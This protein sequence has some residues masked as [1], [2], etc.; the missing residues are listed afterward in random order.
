VLATVTPSGIPTSSRGGAAVIAATVALA[1][2]ALA[3][4]KLD[5]SVLYVLPALVLLVLLTLRRYPGERI[6]AVLSGAR[7]ERPRR[8][9]SSLPLRAR[10]QVAVPRGGLLLACSLA[11]RPPPSVQ[12]AAS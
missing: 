5:P 12:L 8:A 2:A 7:P 4:V 6:L 9:R 3:L 1:I 10:S 11:V